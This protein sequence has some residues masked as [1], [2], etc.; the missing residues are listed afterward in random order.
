MVSI[1]LLNQYSA[2]INDFALMQVDMTF[3]FQPLDSS[4][5]ELR[6]NVNDHSAKVLIDMPH[7]S[8]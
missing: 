7:S 1:A 2:D 6:E 8:L 4:Y 3:P 5:P